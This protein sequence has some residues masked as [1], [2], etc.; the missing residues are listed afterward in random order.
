MI[1]S[2]AIRLIAAMK[3]I[4]LTPQGVAD[5]QKVLYR[6]DDARL[7]NESLAV[8]DDSLSWTARHFEI[9]VFM[10]ERMRNLPAAHLRCLG[11]C[12]GRKAHW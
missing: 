11:W 10:L 2:F 9:N 6:L 1:S 7:L 5:F 8:A 4:P 12:P 3:K